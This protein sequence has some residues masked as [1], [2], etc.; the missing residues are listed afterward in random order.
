[1]KTAKKFFKHLVPLRTISIFIGLPTDLQKVFISKE[2]LFAVDLF[3]YY[4]VKEK[5]LL[6][7]YILYQIMTLVYFSGPEFYFTKIC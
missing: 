1:V 6:S 7:D 4:F 5:T 2:V 3:S